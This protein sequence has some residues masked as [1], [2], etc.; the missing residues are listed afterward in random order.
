ME[1]QSRYYIGVIVLVIVG[2][3]AL[4]SSSFRS[5]SS[6]ESVL[7][8]ISTQDAKAVADD[9][10]A[11]QMFFT[12]TVTHTITE[13]VVPT[14]LT[15]DEQTVLCPTPTQTV[16]C[17]TPTFSPVANIPASLDDFDEEQQQQQQQQQQHVEDEVDKNLLEEDSLPIF[18]PIPDDIMDAIK[19]N[20]QS[21]G[22]LIV[23]VVN[24]GM[25]NYTLNWIASLQRTKVSKYLVFCIDSELYTVL[26]DAGES[27][28]AVEVPAS[29][30]HRTVPSSS[31]ETYKS[32]SYFGV[33]HAKSLV[34]QRLLHADVQ[35]LF[36][37]VDLVFLSP[38]L[39]G[40]INGMY[41]TREETHMLFSQEGF[42]HTTI[43]SGFYFMRP[44]NITRRVLMDTISIQD[45]EP[46]TTQQQAMNRALEKLDLNMKTSPVVHLDLFFFPHGL[47]F[48]KNNIPRRWGTDSFIAHAN[49]YVGEDKMKVLK[50]EGL[51]YL[52]QE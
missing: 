40:F 42:D 12:I 16:L 35:L 4:Y 31:F 52:D 46:K 10:S 36:S 20:T 27:A 14:K 1:R 15:S 23:A 48:F 3:S 19:A 9:T 22:T 43:N 26:K 28:H 2:L 8:S 13:T 6:S 21:D 34:V 51:W 33:T 49:Y 25:V 32:I 41:K 47:A 18:E 17:P 29:W 30:Y 44:T 50:R 11:Q 37:D 38:H 7:Y 39:M 24:S 45:A 5:V